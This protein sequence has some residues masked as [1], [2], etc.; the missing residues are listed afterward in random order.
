MGRGL[1]L[2]KTGKR[3]CDMPVR[4]D[5]RNTGNELGSSWEVAQRVFGGIDNC[6]GDVVSVEDGTFTVLWRD[7]GVPVIYPFDT[8]MVRKA[9]PWELT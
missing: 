7:Y 8:A 5:T 2:R 6:P 1:R 4:S 3:R 9:F